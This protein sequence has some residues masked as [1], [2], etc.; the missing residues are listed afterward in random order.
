MG[1][2]RWLPALVFP[3]CLWTGGCAHLEEVPGTRGHVRASPRPSGSIPEP[4]RHSFHLAAPAPASVGATYSVVVS[5]MDAHDLL[6]SLARDARLNL[7]IHPDIS[8]SVTLNAVDQT[9][10]QLLRRIAKQID[11]RFELDGRTLSVMPDSPTLRLYR[12]DYVN[13]QRNIT[14]TVATN[15][16]ISTS[17]SG[18]PSAS[19]AGPGGNISATRIE[20][21]VR[22]HFWDSVEHN[23]RDILRETDRL[24]PDGSSATVVES[25]QSQATTGTGAP[26]PAASTAKKHPTA[27]A[28][29][30]AASPNPATV[31]SAGTTVTRKLNYIEAASVIINRESGVISVRATARQHEKVREFIDSISAAARRQVLIETTIVEVALSDGYRQGIEWSRLRSDGSGWSVRDP[32]LDSNTGSAVAPFVLAYRGGKPLDLALTLRLLETFGTVKVL[33]SPKLSVLNN[34]TAMLKV[35]EEYVYF[36][37]K[38]DT[39]QTGTNTALTTVTSSPQSVAVGLVMSLTPQISEDDEIILNVRPT[40]SSIADFKRDPNPQIPAGMENLVPQIRTREI[41]SVLRLDNGET[42]LLGGLMEDRV[43]F[44]SGRIPL[45]GSVPLLGEA[46][47]ERNNGAQ[48][49]ELVVFL[50]PRIAHQPG[51]DQEFADLAGYLP[52]EDFFRSAASRRR[53]A[54]AFSAPS[55]EQ[56]E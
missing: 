34:Q 16:Q 12:L 24:M 22:N 41:E 38:A 37:I 27:P 39:I 14:G 13:L 40:I 5:R 17:G 2:A 35:V 26:P 23:L 7:D 43:D 18:L 49:T 33:S 30:L 28:T 36:N 52:E 20:N 51:L 8:G 21:T 32:M 3:A 4:V 44:R 55:P 47:T 6:F 29:S 9:L 10:P 19:L 46:F 15:T 11:M 1:F 31:Q 54:P 25:E 45:L 53:G 56:P 48:K 50:H 42:A